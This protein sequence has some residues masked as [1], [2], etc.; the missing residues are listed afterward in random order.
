MFQSKPSI[1]KRRPTRSVW[2]GQIAVGGN[3]PIRVQSM[4]TADT[5]NT[6]AVLKEMEKL[7]DAGCEIVRV[8]VP[9]QADCDNLPQ[10]RQAMKHRGIKVP[11][12]ADIHFTPSIAMKCVEYVDKVRV[13]P[14]NFV[15]KKLFKTQEY[16]DADY[17]K[18]IDRLREKFTPLVLKCKEYDVAMRVGTNHGSLSDRIMNRYGDTP[19]GM[20]ESAIEF[21]Q[22]CEENDFHNVVLSMK[23]S[24]VQVM[25]TAY[26]SLVHRLDA[27]GW[28]YPLHLGVTEAGEGEDGRIKSAVGIGALLEDGLGD[29]IRVSLTED[30]EYEIPVAYSLVRKYNN[31]FINSFSQKNES[32]SIDESTT[33]SKPYG[34]S[35]KRRYSQAFNIGPLPH[36]A[37]NVPRVWLSCNSDNK[38]EITSYLESKSNEDFPL[39]GIEFSDSSL[40]EVF[41]KYQS[42]STALKSENP[43]K[44]IQ[45]G[46]FFSKYVAV[47]DSDTN[48]E[49]YKDLLDKCL[50]TDQAIEWRLNSIS[51]I[52]ELTQNILNLCETLKF[53]NIFFSIQSDEIVYPYRDCVEVLNQKKCHAPV[54]LLYRPQNS[55][56]LLESA[57]NTGTLFLDGTG[58]S[59][60]IEGLPVKETLSLS[61]QIL[62][63]CRLRI[64]R[65]EY[66]SCPSCGRTLFDLQ[67]TTQKVREATSHLKGVKIAVMGCIVN[68]PGEMADADFGYVGTGPEKISL[69]VGHN[70]VKRNIP[71]TEAVQSLVDLIKDH[72]QW[73]DPA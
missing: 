36:G 8:T 9:T 38:N 25:T 30:P 47:V 51:S 23:A 56:Y 45:N 26:R 20:V 53:E 22:I 16:T 1:Y 55:A 72:G 24:N 49:D 5:K 60:Q 33:S 12:V 71:E 41:E 58:D 59:L 44:L 66:I 39:E 27:L 61:Y 69:Y 13:N 2:L 15:D 68:G 29:T 28:H 70:C 65:A 63:A 21:L 62:Q 34:F 46:D 4:T 18:E 17:Q 6:E 10:I 57:I 73:L 32:F 52:K 43:S 40:F 7:I 35:Y 54:H 48:I 42:I 37:Q 19:E 31:A 67:S 64:S 50:K 3:Y 14:G 11:L